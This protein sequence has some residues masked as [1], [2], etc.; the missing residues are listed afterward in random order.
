VRLSNGKKAKNILRQKRRKPPSDLECVAYHEAGHAVAAY[1]LKRR[2]NYVTIIRE[3]DTLGQCRF[4]PYKNFRPDIYSDNKT[5]ARVEQAIVMLFAGAAAENKL[6]GKR[7]RAGE[8]DDFQK[9]V[10]LAASQC[11]SD[12]EVGAYLNWLWVRTRVL[13]DL[14]WLWAAVEALAQ[15]LLKY[16]K[17][18]YQK[19][20]KIIKEAT[21]V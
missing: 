4:T 6:A 14:P 15:E 5:K 7:N 19:A 20:C 16:R 17:V 18:S 9:A 11:G 12:E 21:D 13:L 1:N 8:D 2:F 10:N 3:D